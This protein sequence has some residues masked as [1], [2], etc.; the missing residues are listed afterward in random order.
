MKTGL[1]RL[2]W[3]LMVC[4]LLFNL[5]PAG[6]GATSWRQ[7]A[8]SGRL[9]QQRG[10]S[11]GAG[12]FYIS[13]LGKL[14]ATRTSESDPAYRQ[15][16]FEFI[17]DDI[18]DLGVSRR[19]ADAE[20]LAKWKVATAEAMFGP[21]SV[22][23]VDAWHDLY[24][25]YGVQQKSDLQSSAKETMKQRMAETVRLNP[26]KNQEIMQVFAAKSKR[27]KARLGPALQTIRGALD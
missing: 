7:D 9:V 10:D 2:T 14:R 4:C 25:L 18:L 13:A 24:T 5:S 22:S 15:L 1:Q 6:S 23:A 8:Q 27:S 3:Q 17:S 21:N 26:N 19:L 11:V 12:R 16:F 20:N